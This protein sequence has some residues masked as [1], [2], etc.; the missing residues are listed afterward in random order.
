MITL[1]K[2][3]K[4]SCEILGQFLDI[5]GGHTVYQQHGHIE[6]AGFIP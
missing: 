6:V 1:V 3:T 2:T 4:V 5:L